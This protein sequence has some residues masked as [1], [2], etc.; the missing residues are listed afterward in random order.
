MSD[1]KATKVAVM[2]VP[3]TPDEA[4]FK[5]RFTC[6]IVGT[7]LALGAVMCVSDPFSLA[8]AAQKANK[9]SLRDAISFAVTGNFSDAKVS[10]KQIENP[11]SGGSVILRIIDSSI[12]KGTA[13]QP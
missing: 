4:R 11:K 12:A 10:L 13:P 6:G 7:F 3:E 5:R 9:Q 1:E 8:N 2:D